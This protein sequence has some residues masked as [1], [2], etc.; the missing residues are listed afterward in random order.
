MFHHSMKM[1]LTA[2]TRNSL[3]PASA[4]IIRRLTI[5][6]YKFLN[7]TPFTTK[8]P[9]NVIGIGITS[10]LYST[11]TAP[12]P[13]PPPPQD[14]NAKGQKILNRISRAFTFSFSTLLVIGATGI[15]GLVVY[16]ILSELFLPSGDTRTFNK[17]IKLVE[18]D[19]N[20]RKLL[21]AEPGERLRAYGETTAG[22]WVRNRPVQSIRVQGQDGSDR[23]AMKFHVESKAGYHGSVSLEQIDKSFWRSD[24][25][26]I[27]LDVAKHNRVYIIEPKFQPK[28]YVPRNS[29]EGGFLG[30]KWGPKK[31]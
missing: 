29:G 23:L 19:E 27:A 17:A 8:S 26:Y 12:P 5:L 13:P 10:R 30:V 28:K 24:F 15:A 6:P 16:L 21:H 31:E 1:P 14:K 7:K 11:K 18:K 25:A 4:S 22:K 3:R 20:V 2:T 9:I